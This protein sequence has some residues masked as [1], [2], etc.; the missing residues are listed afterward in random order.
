MVKLGGVPVLLLR[1]ASGSEVGLT[2]RPEPNLT[3]SLVDPTHCLPQLG[4]CFSEAERVREKALEVA[5]QR[6]RPWKKWMKLSWTLLSPEMPQMELKVPRM[7]RP[8][9]SQKYQILSLA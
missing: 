8:G 4:R 6:L 5:R 7:T 3:Q 1:F 9:N 2:Y